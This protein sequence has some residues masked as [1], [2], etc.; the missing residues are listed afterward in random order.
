MLWVMG[1]T[2]RATP[3]VRDVPSR[4]PG[5]GK[6]KRRTGLLSSRTF[7]NVPGVRF[8]IG[9]KRA[10]D[11]TRGEGLADEKRTKNVDCYKT[12]TKQLQGL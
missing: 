2:D 11:F 12:V 4:P 3:A 8:S 7:R 5:N 6:A 9:G 1:A 10:V